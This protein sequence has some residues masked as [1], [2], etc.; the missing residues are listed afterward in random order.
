MNIDL[1]PIRI[2][3]LC[4]ATVLALPVAAQEK[5]NAEPPAE[6]S[7]EEVLALAVKRM[8]QLTAVAF[9]TTETQ[10]S[11]MSRQVAKQV[12]GVGL[13]GG[14]GSTI[15][16]TWSDGVLSARVNDDGDRVVL[17]RGRMVARNDDIEWKPR[18]SRLVDGAAMPF[19]MD[20]Q[21]TFEA[22]VALPKAA[23]RVARSE[24]GQYKDRDVLI[25][26]I[27]L[28]G[29]AAQDF[30]LSGTL[31]TVS[32]RM[33]GAMAFVRRMGM[34]PG[35]GGALP[36][37]TVDLALYVD[38][39]T[40]YV[41]KMK[42]RTYQESQAMGNVQ[43]QIAGGGVLGGGGGDDEDEDED[44]LREKDAKGRRI[45][46]RGLPVRRLGDNV[47]RMDFDIVLSKHDRPVKL[48]LPAAAKQLLRLRRN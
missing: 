46:K 32:S 3:S 28:E 33:G 39:T 40:G 1:R 43:I 41:H 4:A 45:Y 10:N 37:L 5:S 19:V 7:P 36:E 35:G 12:G 27:T 13:M 22:L 14:G 9:R 47:S 18:R 2:V 17:Y 30:A 29:E 48:G 42:S 31:P 38:P 25:L 6:R 11:A 23:R 34:G 26:S 15:R 8:S 20:P 16:G 24:K 21:R 44:E